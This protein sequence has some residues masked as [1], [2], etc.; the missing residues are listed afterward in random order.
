MSFALYDAAESGTLIWGP[1]SHTAVP[2]SEGLFSVGLGSQTS[3]GIPTTTWN[4]DRYLEITVGGETLAP[5]ELIRSVPIAGMALTVPDGAIG[6]AQIADGAVGTAALANQAT[7]QVVHVE[8]LSEVSNNTIEWQV[9]PDMVATITTN[10]GPVWIN[11]H[12][13][14]QRSV[15]SG[16]GIVLKLN[17][18]GSNVDST[19]YNY[20]VA[21]ANQAHSAQFTHIID[22]EPGEHTIQVMWRMSGVNPTGTMSTVTMRQ[23]SIVEFKR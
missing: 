17:V 10:G 22:L 4:G 19:I 11:F 7:T 20:R 16:A 18:D 9:I 2:V 8:S 6:A 15:A 5:R 13:N 21:V 12:T 23:L 3:G 1:E 14:Y